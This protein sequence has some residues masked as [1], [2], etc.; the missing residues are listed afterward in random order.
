MVTPSGFIE[1][2]PSPVGFGGLFLS[3]RIHGH[4]LGIH[5]SLSISSRFWWFVSLSTIFFNMLVYYLNDQ[6]LLVNFFCFSIF[7]LYDDFYSFSSFSLDLL[8][9]IFV[10]VNLSFDLHLVI[11]VARISCTRANLSAFVFPSSA[12]CS[13]MSAISSQVSGGDCLLTLPP[14]GVVDSEVS[15][16]TLASALS[17][18]VFKVFA[19][20]SSASRSAT[21]D[22]KAATSASR[23]AFSAV[24]SWHCASPSV[25]SDL[26]QYSSSGLSGLP[27]VYTHPSLQTSSGL[28]PLSSLR[29]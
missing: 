4:T 23:L 15:S 20:A 24:V 3:S 18:S 29:V 19:A 13:M 8:I 6:F 7:C 16:S 14:S 26:K 1:A 5:R 21:S 25:T 22:S 2:C 17:S 28:S 12:S 11:P 9:L 27:L 10:F